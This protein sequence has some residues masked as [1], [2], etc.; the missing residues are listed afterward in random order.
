[1]GVAAWAGFGWL[2]YLQIT[3]H[4]PDQWRSEVGGIGILL[5]AFTVLTLA[6]VRWNRNIYR[7]RHR[8]VAPLVVPVSFAHDTQGRQIAAP[9]RLGQSAGEIVVSLDATRNVKRYEL[10][11]AT[12]DAPRRS[13]AGGHG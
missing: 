8:R 2:W 5:V 1:M 4:L 13:V 7:R 12:V 10:R 11:G 3:Q 9:L 6:W